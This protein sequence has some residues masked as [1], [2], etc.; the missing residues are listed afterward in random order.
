MQKEKEIFRKS[1]RPKGSRR[2]L[3]GVF[4]MK[5]DGTIIKRGT[6]YEGADYFLEIFLIGTIYR[7]LL[8]N[9]APIGGSGP[10]PPPRHLT[11]SLAH[12][13]GLF[14]SSSFPL[15][16]ARTPRQD[17]R[18]FIAFCRHEAALLSYTEPPIRASE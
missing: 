10:P 13:L 18:L 7:I 8:T 9:A 16:V 3:R 4:L 17:R 12:P 14:S 2:C 5:I 6:A 1:A 11:S 15:T